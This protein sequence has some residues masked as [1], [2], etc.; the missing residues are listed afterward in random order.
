MKK[1]PIFQKI[2]VPLMGLVMLEILILVSGIFGS[3]LIGKLAD[4]ERAIVDEM[5]SGRRDYLENVMV[6][7]WMNVDYTV[8]RINAQTQRLL[9]EGSISLAALDDS[10]EESLPLL[11]EAVDYLISMMRSN[12]VSGAFLILNT[13]DLSGSIESGAYKDKPGIYLRDSNPI[14]QYSAQNQD[15]LVERAP[16]S[17]VHE[18]GIAADSFWSPNFGFHE[19]GQAYY[20]FLYQPFQ[21]AYQ[22]KSGYEWKDM[23]YWSEPFQ[24]FG[25][26]KTAIA[27]SVPLILE[28]GT[29][30]GVLGID[31]TRDYFST[32][33]PY[34]EIAGNDR[35]AYF[36][37]KCGEEEGV[38]Y[39]AFGDGN[40]GMQ[41]DGADA[42]LALDAK[43]YYVKALALGNYNSN[44]P[45]FNDKWV[46]A[47]AVPM[48]RLTAFSR[49]VSATLAVAILVTL[50]VG[51]AGSFLISYMIQ[52]PVS[53]LSKA[54]GEQDPRT[55][56]RL[57][58][59]GISEIDRMAEAMEKLS[60]NVIEGDMKF[61][62]IIRMAS[63]TLAGFQINYEDNSL[64]ATENFFSVFGRPDIDERT[65][66]VERF[67]RIMDSFHCYFL[68]Y[69]K[70]NDSYIYRIRQN[71][72]ERYVQLKY[73][74]DEKN[75]YGLCEDVTRTIQEKRTLQHERDHDLL[76]NLY[77]RRAFLREVQK[78]FGEHLQDIHMGALIMMDL[79]NLKYVNDS[80]G[81]AYGD[82]YI[83][84]AAAVMRECLPA[85]A[86]YARISGDEF[87]IF[88]YGCHSRE[89]IDEQIEK[90]RRGMSCAFI[91]LPDKEK[92]KVQASG[93]VAWYPKDSTSV[94]DLFK[95]AD[96]AMYEVKKNGKGAIRDFDRASY[97]EQN[98]L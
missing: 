81:H 29:V 11:S 80:F 28:D 8:E 17:L 69:D 61:T 51:A 41:R 67:D 62:K 79:D 22:D 44:T 93:G 43:E 47:G 55:S 6:G 53:L 87:Y 63:V 84:E 12:C 39:G 60:R 88:I 57:Q 56:I 23:G 34:G 86:L 36:L 76:T 25:E 94:E 82:K 77:N 64:F 13:E 27:Y 52:K 33:L 92:Y 71:D 46:L 74:K 78:L 1:K 90:I 40:L 89:E 66:S 83:M 15:L 38:F 16:I 3:G 96:F 73:M 14:S 98:I 4:N 26:G 20:D 58:D 97:E 65:L 21:T 32:L 37:A 19:K 24:L 9:D 54:L 2:L 49:Q 75:C 35:G 42:R 59:T 18:L 91:A 5:I 85:N 30:Y 10:S 48:T 70:V 50:L 45:F 95:Y 7:N 68:E 72:S 31:I